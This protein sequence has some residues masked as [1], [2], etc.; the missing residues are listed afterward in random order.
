MGLNEDLL[1][2]GSVIT[3]NENNITV[4]SGDNRKREIYYKV[5]KHWG[6][7]VGVLSY[8]VDGVEKVQA[9]MDAAK[10][11]GFLGTV[12]I[13]EEMIRRQ[14]D[15]TEYSDFAFNCVADGGIQADKIVIYDIMKMFEY[16]EHTVDRKSLLNLVELASKCHVKIVGLGNRWHSIDKRSFIESVL[17]SGKDRVTVTVDG[18]G[19][20]F[21]GTEAQ[22][23]QELSR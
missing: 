15:R 10:E 18:N 21:L 17:F 5:K 1:H 12:T 8:K 14:P 13:I 2:S 22:V 7:P 3:T 9:D 19:W 20:M 6:N 23:R 4:I 16:R 11:S